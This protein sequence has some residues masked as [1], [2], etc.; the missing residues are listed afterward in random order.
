[1]SSDRIES[2]LQKIDTELWLALRSGDVSALE[3]I[4]DRHVDIVYAVSLRVLSNVQEAEDLTQEIFVKLFE[5]QAYDPTRGSLRT[6]LTLLARSRAI[7]RLRRRQSLHRAQQKL[8]LEGAV[9]GAVDSD[10]TGRHV[11]EKEQS[12]AVRAALAQLS[13]AQRQV[14]YLA[15]YEGLTQLDISDCLD[16]PL[17]TVKART[18]RGLLKLRELLGHYREKGEVVNF[19]PTEEG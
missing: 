14:L 15:Y 9:S 19:K 13:E 17:G 7:D 12:E 4:Y 10:A 6:F 5:N 8:T 2:D 11:F 1:M 18:R 3:H 16:V